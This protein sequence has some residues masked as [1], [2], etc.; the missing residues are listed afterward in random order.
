MLERIGASRPGRPGRGLPRRGRAPRVAGSEGAD[1]RA[2][3][4]G[5]AMDGPYSAVPAADL[6][7]LASLR[8]DDLAA[9][10]GT[11]RLERALS[12]IRDR[13]G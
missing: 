9:P 10:D 6:S 4:Q 2:A 8:L 5:E 13:L 1:P 3:A 11:E 7:A 12:E